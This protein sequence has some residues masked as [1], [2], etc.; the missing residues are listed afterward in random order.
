MSR[1][2]Q[3]LPSPRSLKA[4]TRTV[5]PTSRYRFRSQRSALSA[6][7][8]A[9]WRSLTWGAPS[10]RVRAARATAGGRPGRIAPNAARSGFCGSTNEQVE[11]RALVVAMVVAPR[12]LVEIPLQPLVGHLLV[13]P[14]DAGLEVPK[15]ALDRVR[16]YV[17]DDVL[18]SGVTNSTMAS[19]VSAEPVVR[20]PLVRV[21]DRLGIDPLHDLPVQ[22]RPAPRRHDGRLDAAA[23]FDCGEHRRST[24]FAELHRFRACVGG[25]AHRGFLAR[26]TIDGSLVNL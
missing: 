15:E 25:G 12:E 21:D 6:P 3:S 11:H 18:A 5:S 2:A 24:T 17:A 1:L 23:A 9:R 14:P 20:R 8:S 19:E 16:V 26:T 13:V 7:R 4:A 10:S 22:V